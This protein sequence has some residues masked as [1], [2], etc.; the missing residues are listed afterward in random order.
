MC[1]LCSQSP[2]ILTPDT[3]PPSHSHPKPYTIDPETLN[4]SRS[5][6]KSS[7]SCTLN[8]R[9]E[10]LP[11]EG[12]EPSTLTPPLKPLAADTLHPST[13]KRL[14]LNSSL[15]RLH[16]RLL[17]SPPHPKLYTLKPGTL[18]SDPLQP[19]HLI[20]QPMLI[21]PYTWTPHTQSP[22]PLTAKPQ[23]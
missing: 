4:R 18:N 5:H 14:T 10:P 19:I 6:S 8:C 11:S 13:H 7:C 15:A 16:R 17:S 20:R 1:S 23:T 22:T 3:L 21:A 9:P 2:C 12:L